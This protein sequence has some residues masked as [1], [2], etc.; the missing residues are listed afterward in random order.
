MRT[1]WLRNCFC[2]LGMLAMLGTMASVP[3]ASVN[4]VAPAI[5]M[6]MATMDTSAAGSEGCR[7]QANPCP[8]CSKKICPELASCLVQCVNSLPA[9]AAN[10]HRRVTN[11]KE[12]LPFSSAPSP[13]GILISPLIRPPIV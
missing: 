2:I 11:A 8:E 3:L 7:K 4:A 6:N 9:P 1:A 13:A 12:D 10:E 5:N